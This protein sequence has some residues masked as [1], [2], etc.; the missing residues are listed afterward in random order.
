MEAKSCTSILLSCKK[1]LEDRV[2]VLICYAVPV[3]GDEDVDGGGGFPYS[4]TQS[5]LFR[6]G[7][8]RV[9]N[10]IGDYLQYLSRPYFSRK[11]FRDFRNEVNL[12]F[13]YSFAMD[14]E[15]C[16]CRVPKLRI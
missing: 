4:Q 8:E 16:V 14:T 15:C 11:T 7:V 13:G 12:F 3:I 1:G 10:Q 5:T 2:R 6:K 9:G